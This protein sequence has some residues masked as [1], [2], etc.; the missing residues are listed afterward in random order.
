LV[1]IVVA[2][3]AWVGWAAPAQGY[4]N[5]SA[6]LFN[7]VHSSLGT[8]AKAITPTVA[9]NITPAWGKPFKPAGGFFASPIV[10]NG[11]VYIGGRSGIFYQVSE[12]TGAVLNSVN[13]GTENACNAGSSV[14]G[15]TATAT[16]A[17][18]PSR[19]GAPTVYV[20]GG[21]GG[22]G[23]GGI[24]LWAL[25]A[26]DL[27]PVWATDP[28]PVSTEAGAYAWSSPTVSGGRISVGI[29]SACDVPLVRGGLGIF[30]QSTGSLVG[31]YYTVPSGS[32]GGGIWSSAAVSGSSTWVTTG[33]GDET[34]GANQGDSFAIARLH[35]TTRVD[36]WTV[37]GQVGTDNDFG[38]SPTLF[39]GLVGGVTTSLVGACN[40]N[41]IFYALPSQSLSG[42]PVWTYQLAAAPSTNGD[43]CISAAVWDR[44]K[45]QLLIGSPQ[46][47]IPIDGSQWAG[48][49]Q[50]LSPDADATS[51]VIWAMGLPCPV[52]GTPAENSEG[53]LAL[54]TEDGCSAGGSPSLYLLNAR[55]ATPNPNGVPNPKLLKVIQ[56]ASGAFSQPTFADSYLFVASESGGL[57]AYH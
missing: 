35:G 28:V 25:D 4:V 39:S 42:G 51:R 19:G 44:S 9:T 14:P 12:S 5:W 8:G 50:S 20:T 16:V 57:M 41:G 53:V 21:S 29:A 17:P 54:V 36:I 7:P 37:P 11:S 52:L 26:G 1:W 24:Y 40:K 33:N 45:H 49:I 22:A 3:C 13:L 31:D 2:A 46:T 18:D 15:I 55:V 43:T 47:A 32:I 27:H 56:L 48:S 10:Y 23:N 30:K 6:Y 34:A 38:A